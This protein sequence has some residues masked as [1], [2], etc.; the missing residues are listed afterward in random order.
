MRVFAFTAWRRVSA[1][2]YAVAITWTD[3]HTSSIYSF[4]VL[5]SIA[6]HLGLSK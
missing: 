5:R 2:N 4:E 3:G 1:G 6:K